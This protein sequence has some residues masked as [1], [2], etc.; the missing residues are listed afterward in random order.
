[1]GNDYV[2]DYRGKEIIRLQNQI[3]ELEQS[4]EI[5]NAENYV[6][7]KLFDARC[8][9]QCLERDNGELLSEIEKL[10]EENKELWD[11]N[12]GLH[13]YKTEL[14]DEITQLNENVVSERASFKMGRAEVIEDWKKTDLRLNERTQEL[15]K[16]QDQIKEFE[17][18]REKRKGLEDGKAIM[19][20]KLRT[21]GREML[22]HWKHLPVEYIPLSDTIKEWEE[23]ID[24]REESFVWTKTSVLEALVERI[25]KLE[26]TVYD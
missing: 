14:K 1:M 5:H 12:R 8:T 26:G 17:K 22:E 25:E 2:Y 15:F 9:I 11:D 23:V 18:A 16:A 20:R 19:I 24:T 6:D 3:K 10:K 4:A 7:K 13:K 21:A